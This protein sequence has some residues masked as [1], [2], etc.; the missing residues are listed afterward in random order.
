MIVEVQARRMGT[1]LRTG[2]I[3]LLYVVGRELIHAEKVKVTGLS[4]KRRATRRRYRGE[5]IGEWAGRVGVRYLWATAESAQ[6][7]SVVAF[8]DSWA[9]SNVDCPAG[10]FPISANGSLRLPP[11]RPRTHRTPSCPP[12]GTIAS[13]G[14]PSETGSAREGQRRPPPVPAPTAY[15]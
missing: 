15:P 6:G 8:R 9:Y 2:E 5:R 7:G 1:T 4:A 12:D 10:Y 14:P 3:R 13:T 11:A